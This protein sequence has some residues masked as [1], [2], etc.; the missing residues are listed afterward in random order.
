MITRSR[1]LVVVVLSCLL[2][3]A[4]SAS[5]ECAWL[6][7]IRD[8]NVSPGGVRVEWSPP[9]AFADRAACMAFLDAR[10]KTWKLSANK[11]QSAIL[12]ETG[13]AAEFRTHADAVMSKQ[14]ALCLPDTVDPR[15]PKGGK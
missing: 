12:E 7:W 2:A 1:C 14:N 11:N 15:G 8:T 13:T 4:T 10:V 3:L 5:A 6:L 9:V